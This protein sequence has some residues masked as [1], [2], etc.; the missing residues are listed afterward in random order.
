MPTGFYGAADINAL[1]ADFGVPVTVGAVTAKGLEDAA[2]ETMLSAESGA[3]HLVGRVR[4]VLVKTGT[5]TLA[6]KA[7]ITVDGTA[8]KVRDYAQI[9]DGALTRIVCAKVL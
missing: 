4:V 7:D 5:F 8:Y 9:D 6:A 3:A 2:D 1:L